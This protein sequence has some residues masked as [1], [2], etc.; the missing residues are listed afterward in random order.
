MLEYL[1]YWSI[2]LLYWWVV[3][4][5]GLTS[6]TGRG[7]RVQILGVTV[8]EENVG[9]AYSDFVAEFVPGYRGA[10]PSVVYPVGFMQWEDGLTTAQGLLEIAREEGAWMIVVGIPKDGSWDGS[11]TERLKDLYK[12]ITAIL[13]EDMIL[14]FWCEKL[15]GFSGLEDFFG[16][17]RYGTF[18]GGPDA[19]EMLWSYV[20]LWRQSLGQR[21]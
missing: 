15:S 8:G 18:D 5:R 12:A 20:E 9:I 6:R 13:P 10:A 11:R 19:T 21:W 3:G 4:F 2:S 16:G 1:V 14:R 7:T 17:Q